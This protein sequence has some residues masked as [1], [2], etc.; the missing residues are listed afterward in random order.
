M[1]N[2]T[3]WEEERARLVLEAAMGVAQTRLIREGLAHV[4]PEDLELAAEAE[5]AERMFA[6]S[7]AATTG[8]FPICFV[9]GQVDCDGD[10]RLAADAA[11]ELYDTLVAA[12]ITPLDA[13]PPL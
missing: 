8:R 7:F 13:D 6:A 10:W 5:A 2:K 1:T 4:A 9:N 11:V 3:A 12:G